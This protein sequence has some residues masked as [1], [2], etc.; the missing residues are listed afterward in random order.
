V[1]K[2]KRSKDFMGE[3]LDEGEGDRVVCESVNRDADAALIV[4][5]PEMLDALN[6]VVE[7][8]VPINETCHCATCNARRLVCR[9]N[10]SANNQSKTG[11]AK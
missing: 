10:E 5:A 3:I 11:G 7:N 2:W 4:A 6:M 1:R 8:G 9:I